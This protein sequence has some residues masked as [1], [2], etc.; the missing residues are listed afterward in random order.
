MLQLV[1]EL[2]QRLLHRPP[3]DRPVR[4]MGGAPGGMRYSNGASAEY[5]AETLAWAVYYPSNLPNPTMMN[6]LK[7]NVF[8]R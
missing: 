7:A 2:V 6:W 8:Y 1:P 4:E 5:F 3:A